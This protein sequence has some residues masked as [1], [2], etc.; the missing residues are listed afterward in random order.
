MFA[1]A[2][3]FGT[4]NAWSRA[5]IVEYAENDCNHFVLAYADNALVGYA[6][7]SV[8]FDE[9]EL[10]NIAVLPIARRNG[11]AK[12]MLK[13]L[14]SEL[15]SS[16]VQKLH[17]EVR[18]SNVPARA[19]YESFG[20]SIDCKRKGYYSEPREDAILMTLNFNEIKED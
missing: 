8:L 19:L 14:V 17:L 1:E 13:S 2:E 4:K 7:V 12:A 10:A 16:D 18:E 15:K 3:C 11:I 6:F 5:S 20:F 9:A